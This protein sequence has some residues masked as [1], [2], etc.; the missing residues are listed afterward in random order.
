M[1]RTNDPN[2]ERN[3]P[4]EDLTDEE[5]NEENDWSWQNHPALTI[6]QRNS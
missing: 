3:D 5:W 1:L 6:E 2:E 4:P